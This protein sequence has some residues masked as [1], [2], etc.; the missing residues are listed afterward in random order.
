MLWRERLIR[1]TGIMYLTL[2]YTMLLNLMPSSNSTTI[3][4]MITP[5]HIY[6]C[7]NKVTATNATDMNELS[8]C[9]CLPNS[10]IS[11]HPTKTTL[12]C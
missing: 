9:L 4:P 12:F 8:K 5:F 2:S 10:A 3:N 11:K 6:I 1:N 7:L